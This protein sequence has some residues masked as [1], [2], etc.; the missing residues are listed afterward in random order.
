MANT[1]KKNF[2]SEVNKLIAN[3]PVYCY[4]ERFAIGTLNGA[5]AGAVVLLPAVRGFKYRLVHAACVAVG[6]TTAG[7]TSVDIDGVQSG[8]VVH[9]VRFLL[10]GLARSLYDATGVLTNAVV[11]ADGAGIADCDENT[12]ISVLAEGTF[13]GATHFDIQIAYTLEKAA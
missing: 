8:S 1:R 3:A 4:K 13:T 10:A 12:A 2:Q 7:G 9:L 6:G 5:A 11:L